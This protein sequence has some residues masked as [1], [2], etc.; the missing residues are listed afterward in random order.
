MWLLSNFYFEEG[1]M[2]NYFTLGPVPI[3]EPCVQVS[4]DH[5]YLDSMKKECHRYREMLYKRF[6]RILES[7]MLL[8]VKSFPHDF[9][10]YSEVVVNW[11]IDEDGKI[12]QVAAFIEDNLPLTWNEKKVFTKKDLDEYLVGTVDDD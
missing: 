1:L 7:G 10:V 5:P 2:S 4:Q 12:L 9:G 8:L 11:D 3:D 6:E